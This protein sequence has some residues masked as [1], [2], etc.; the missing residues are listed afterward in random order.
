[1]V[2]G[3][4][5]YPR[6]GTALTLEILEG[7]PRPGDVVHLSLATRTVE[8]TIRG[9]GIVDHDIGRPTFHADIV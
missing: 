6:G 5:A 1:V 4:F 8:V 9:T 7:S 2:K 3:S